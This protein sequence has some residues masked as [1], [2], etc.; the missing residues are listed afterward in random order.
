MFFQSDLDGPIKLALVN[1]WVKFDKQCLRGRMLGNLGVEEDTGQERY[2]LEFY[3]YLRDG[4]LKGA[5]VTMPSPQ[6]PFWA[7]LKKEN[8]SSERKQ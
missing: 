4:A 1:P 5:V 3:L 6:L 7:E 2:H 8:E